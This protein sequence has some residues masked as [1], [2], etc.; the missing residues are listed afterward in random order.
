MQRIKNTD[1]IE[2][3]NRKATRKGGFFVPN[4]GK[5]GRMMEIIKALIELSTAIVNLIIAI[6]AVKNHQSKS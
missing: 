5:E 2:S 4:L 3:D 6:I 1:W